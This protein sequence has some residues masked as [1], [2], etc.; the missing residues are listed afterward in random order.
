[1]TGIPSSSDESP[2]RGAELSEALAALPEHVAGRAG[3]SAAGGG[4]ARSLA[5]PSLAFPGPAIATRTRFAL[6]TT[7]DEGASA[8]SLRFAAAGGAL[9]AAAAEAVGAAAAAAVVGAA[10][11]AG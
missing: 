8:A 10:A 9:A 2:A 7:L 11:A 5:F 6:D 3:G 4:A 1:M